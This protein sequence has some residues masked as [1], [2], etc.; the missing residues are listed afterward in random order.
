MIT[1]SE[2]TLRSYT[3]RNLVLDRNCL[4]GFLIARRAL[5]FRTGFWPEIAGE[6]TRHRPDRTLSWA[7]TLN[8]DTYTATHDLLT[9][10]FPG[11][12][13]SAHDARAEFKQYRLV[14]E[15]R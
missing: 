15:A 1:E 8:K 6:L 4:P 12:D 13:S 10:F 7:S 2:W 11:H 14:H 5:R 9:I 3:F